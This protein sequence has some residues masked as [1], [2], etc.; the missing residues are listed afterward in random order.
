MAILA[1]LRVST[2]GTQTT[3][4]QRKAITDYGFAI[5]EWYA[6]DGV[7]GSIEA[8]KRPAFSQMMATAKAGDTVVCTMLDRLGRNAEDIL[9]TINQFQKQGIKVRIMQ[10]DGV[11]VTSPTGK[12]LVTMLSALAEMEKNMLVERT[13]QGLARTKQEGTILGPPLIL[14]PTTLSR[15]CE[16]KDAGISWVAISVATGIPENTVARNVKKWSGKLDEYNIE[17]M[18]RAEQ[19][20]A[21]KLA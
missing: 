18:K 2:F 17:H 1:Y 12:L 19:Y 9:H 16:M 8:L 21:R 4:N 3:E 11:D 5:D 13:L 20:N 14:S 10:L 7:S 6:E 15:M